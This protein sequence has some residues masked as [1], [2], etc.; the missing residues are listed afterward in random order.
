MRMGSSSVTSPP[1]LAAMT[2]PPW[3]STLA[4]TG[5]RGLPVFARKTAVFHAFALRDGA[6]DAAAAAAALPDE[7]AGLDDLDER[8]HAAIF[9]VEENDAAGVK[10]CNS[11]KDGFRRAEEVFARLHALNDEVAMPVKST[12][13]PS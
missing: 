10:P 3:R 9:R 11:G 2:F 12:S 6:G 8:G 4:R 7:G 13:V 5:A 1:M